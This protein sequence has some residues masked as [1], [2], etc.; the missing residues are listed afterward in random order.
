MTSITEVAKVD[1]ASIPIV[2]PGELRPTE[3]FWRDLQPWLAEHGYMLRPRYRPGWIPSWEATGLYYR[4]CEDGI[5][6]T[7]PQVLDATRISDGEIVALKKVSI[8][9]H[10][11]E[12]E[13]GHIF[14]SEP[15]SLDHRN[16]CVPIYEV[17]Q[18]PD[19]DDIVLLVMPLLRDYKE[20]RFQTVGEAVEYFRQVFEGLQYMHEHH[21]AHRDCMDLN[22]MM[23]PKPLYPRLYHPQS[24]LQSLKM[25]K[26]A[27]HYTRTARP[28]RYYFIDFGLSRKYNPDDGPPREDP[29]WGGDKTVP[30]FQTSDDPCDPF[31][32]DIYYLGNMIRE[33]F[34]QPLFGVEFMK[35]LVDDMVQDDP[36][37]RPTINEVVTR[38]E[39]IRRK[40]GYWKLRSRLAE[41]DE[42][43]VIRTYRRV[44]HF[45]RTIGYIVTWRSPMP[46]P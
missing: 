6:I 17:L 39:E 33:D 29:I 4:K 18:V 22:I 14:S 25:G 7:Y 8:S 44:R 28:T 21:V 9:L 46:T 41:K 37:R 31:P 40:L 12:V 24:D 42:D 32:T 30:E 23:D 1:L 35:P 38:F 34:L 15:S 26:L 36:A 27:K 11:Y 43:S 19:Q 10:P 2:G 3:Y 20:P 13:I 45:F 16:H 5:T